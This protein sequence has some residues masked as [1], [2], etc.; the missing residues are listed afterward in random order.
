MLELRRPCRSG[1]T[2]LKEHIMSMEVALAVVL[3]TTP[4]TIFAIAL[5]YAENRTRRSVKS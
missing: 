1:V 4:F 5:A 2:I 3:I